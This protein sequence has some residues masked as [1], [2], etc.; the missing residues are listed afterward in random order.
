[1][2]ASAAMVSL[3]I[4]DKNKPELF[5]GLSFFDQYFQIFLTVSMDNKQV[6]AF[7]R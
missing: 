5:N 6:S 7:K 2:V 3:F 4:D 1:M